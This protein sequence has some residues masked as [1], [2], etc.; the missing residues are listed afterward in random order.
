[1]SFPLLQI[2]I[3]MMVCN[4][5]GGKPKIIQVT[6]NLVTP[7][8]LHI[9]PHCPTSIALT[10]QARPENYGASHPPGLRYHCGRVGK[11]GS[12]WPGVSVTYDHGIHFGLRSSSEIAIGVPHYY[13]TL[14]SLELLIRKGPPSS[15][16]DI[17]RVFAT[18]QFMS[19]NVEKSLVM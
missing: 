3:M 1:M 15:D 12:V 7:R 17:F 4:L 19:R 5:D 16:F 18:R 10:R 13:L 8:R 6:P 9:N 2:I 11:T 14:F